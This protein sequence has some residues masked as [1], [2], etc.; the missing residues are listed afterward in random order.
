[1]LEQAQTVVLMVVLVLL[2]M[3]HL[4]VQIQV[5]VVE[6]VLTAE[7]LI[8]EAQVAQAVV[9]L[10]MSGLRFNNGTFCKN[11]KRFSSTSHCCR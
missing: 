5:A 7:V 2:A 4:L 8:L 1:V 10:F 11:R 9:G 6:A 3:V